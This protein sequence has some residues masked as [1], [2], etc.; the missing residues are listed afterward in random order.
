MLMNTLRLAA[1]L[2][3]ASVVVSC[4]ARQGEPSQLPIEPFSGHVTM[5]A[6]GTWFT[7]CGSADSVRWWVTYVD[8]SVQQSNEAKKKG[9]LA[10]NQR[11]FVRWRASRTDDRLV[12]P[13]GPA[14]LV[15]DIFE[16]RAP[17]SNDCPS[18]AASSHS[19]A[20]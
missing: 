13:G 10:A 8:A 4:A 12:G 15:R 6:T 11:M 7:P 19:R 2:F 16:I 14:L 17:R 20:G 3:S 1:L 5:T 18:Q 9:L